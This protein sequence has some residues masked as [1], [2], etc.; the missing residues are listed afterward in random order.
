MS[1]VIK[2]VLT[3]KVVDVICDICSK[4]CKDSEDM[5]LEYAEIHIPGGGWGYDSGKDGEDHKCQMCEGCYD[6]VRNF[7]ENDL[8]GKIRVDRYL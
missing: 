3:D 7:I 6:K 1:E 2:E 8:G 4:S 5:N